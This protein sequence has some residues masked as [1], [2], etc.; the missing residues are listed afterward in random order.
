MNIGIVT[1]PLVANYGGF[2]QNYALQTALKEIGCNPITLDLETHLNVS[3][4]G[5]LNEIARLFLKRTIMGSKKNYPSYVQKRPSVF[6]EF[7]SKHVNVTSKFK[8]Y[9]PQ[10]IDENQLD[11]VIVGSD[12]VWR[13]RYNVYPEE[14][15]LA[16][17]KGKQIRRAS[18]A[19]SFGVDGWEYD[20]ELTKRCGELVS[21]F[22]AVSVRETSGIALCKEHWGIDA[23]KVLDPT[24]LYE[25]VLYNELC[26]D[27]PQTEEMY[28]AVYA[29]GLSESSKEIIN[30]F[31]KKKGLTTK[32]FTSDANYTLAVPEWVAA[33]RDASFVITDSFHGTAFSIIYNKD[34]YSIINKSRGTSRFE[35][36]LADFGL[37][38]RLLDSSQLDIPETNQDI[39]WDGINE[40]RK[41]LKEQSMTFLRNAVFG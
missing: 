12:Q 13:P 28:V 3:Y 21:N 15:F 37:S 1:Q 6:D 36:I 9:I 14:M 16:F 34:F 24:L 7:V 10:L 18:Y 25:K 35:S 40:K 2:L 17:S 38:D 11:G 26:K 33:I 32:Y 22:D 8:R 4:C 30:S 19:A 29:L 23:K 20:Q 27:V 41:T 5:Y 31:A 39:E